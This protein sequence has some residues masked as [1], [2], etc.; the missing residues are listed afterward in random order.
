[1]GR[2]LDP[3]Q[4]RTHAD[5]LRALIYLESTA[6]AIDSYEVTVIPGLLQTQ[7]YIRALFR[8]GGVAED[9]IEPRVQAR[10]ARQAL[11]DRWEP[12]RL[13]Y[14]IHESALR[15]VVGGPQVMGGQLRHL[16]RLGERGVCGIRI[17]PAAAGARAA[18]VYGSFLRLTH[19]DSST[20]Y[21]E[22]LTTSVFLDSPVDLDLYGRVWSALEACAFTERQSQGLLSALESRCEQRR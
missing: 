10:L 6:L 16:R 3:V 15:I 17:V 18:A 9:R 13:A 1:V 2:L 8:E 20:V 21:V 12:P 4:R 14:F 22:H 11:L 7:E 5:E 19:E